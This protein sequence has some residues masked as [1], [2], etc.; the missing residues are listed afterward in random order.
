MPCNRVVNS[1][2]AG[3][4]GIKAMKKIDD[5]TIVVGGIVAF[6]Y[7]ID[8]LLSYLMYYVCYEL[9]TNGKCL[10]FVI[11]CA[12]FMFLMALGESR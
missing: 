7:L 4:V 1:R 3:C 11:V 8:V 2:D 10:A 6:V 12:L 5:D 9:S